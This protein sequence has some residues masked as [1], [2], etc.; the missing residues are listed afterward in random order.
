MPPAGIA[1]SQEGL[2]SL[3]NDHG[4]PGYD[5]PI[6]HVSHHDKYLPPAEMEITIET[7]SNP[8]LVKY[9]VVVFCGIEPTQP[10]QEDGTIDGLRTS[11]IVIE[12]GRAFANLG[13]DLVYA[14]TF[15]SPTVIKAD[16]LA[17]HQIWYRMSKSDKATLQLLSPSLSAALEL[18]IPLEMGDS[19][20]RKGQGSGDKQ[21]A[22]YQEHQT[23]SI[24]EDEEG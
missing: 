18:M 12:L 19:W 3:M 5:R 11:C 23:P 14:N 9:Y 4:F 1:E 22:D 8:E 6:N 16:L 21:Q 10:R 7:S 2:F 13:V 17:I 24:E 20:V 15:V